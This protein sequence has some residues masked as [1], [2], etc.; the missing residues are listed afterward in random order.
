MTFYLQ[1]QMKQ[2]ETQKEQLKRQQ[3]VLALKIKNSKL[4]KE[5]SIEHLETL[6]EPITHRLNMNPSK[7]STFRET[8]TRRRPDIM[9]VRDQIEWESDRSFPWP[10][11]RTNFLINE[12]IFITLLGIIKKQ[13]ARI[14][15]LEQT[16][17]NL[18]AEF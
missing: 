18:L 14:G 7:I 8:L 9:T 15:E 1:E 12:K 6:I 16:W 17:G 5:A 13:D 4:D 11:A 10:H 2:L 3:D